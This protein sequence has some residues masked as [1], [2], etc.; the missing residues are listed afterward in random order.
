MQ[1]K[2][3]QIERKAEIKQFIEEREKLLSNMH[4]A[5]DM[6]TETLAA[7]TQHNLKDDAEDAKEAKV[8]MFG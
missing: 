5:A 3:K 2:Q 6:L 7:T 8:Y 4:N 1:K